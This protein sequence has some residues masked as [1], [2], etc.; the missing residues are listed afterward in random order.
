[1]KLAVVFLLVV[2]G[3]CR[4]ES[5]ATA[6]E[7]FC[8]C[9]TAADTVSR[10]WRVNHFTALKICEGRMIEK[11]PLYRVFAVDMVYADTAAPVDWAERERS[12]VFMNEFQHYVNAN[13]GEFR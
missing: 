9:V 12:R 6:G 11:Y 3:G 5:G 13:C 7:A 8:A 4:P 1:M 10:D 2:L